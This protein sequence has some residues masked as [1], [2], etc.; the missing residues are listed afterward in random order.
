M[1][2]II[3]NHCHFHFKFQHFKITD[4]YQFEG[5]VLVQYGQYSVQKENSN[6]Y[7]TLINRAIQKYR[8]FPLI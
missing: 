1:P 8:V 2:W 3:K 6:N 5:L 4:C 7:K